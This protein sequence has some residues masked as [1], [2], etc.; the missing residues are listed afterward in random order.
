[1]QNKTNL[2][3][4]G[5]ELLLLQ[6]S[7]EINKKKFYFKLKSKRLT[8]KKNK[9]KLIINR[10]T[11]LLLNLNSFFYISMKNKIHFLSFF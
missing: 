4:H 8:R 6:V 5:V 7:T 2:K 10:K 3:S 9:M 11:T 1:V